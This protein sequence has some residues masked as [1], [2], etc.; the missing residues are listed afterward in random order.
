[1]KEKTT[2]KAQKKNALASEREA[3]SRLEHYRENVS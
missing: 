1:M 3:R 2:Q